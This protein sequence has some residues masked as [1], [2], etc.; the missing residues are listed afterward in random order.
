MKSLTPD[1]TKTIDEWISRE[2]LK[3]GNGDRTSTILRRNIRKFL[4]TNTGYD[5]DKGIRADWK[6]VG[7]YIRE[8]LGMRLVP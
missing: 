2:C 3:V 6:A 5:S 4:L 1:Q 7:N 8:A